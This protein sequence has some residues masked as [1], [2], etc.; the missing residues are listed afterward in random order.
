MSKRHKRDAAFQ[1]KVDEVVA[2]DVKAYEDYLVYAQT[3][4]PAKPYSEDESC[5]TFCHNTDGPHGN[6]VMGEGVMS[7]VIRFCKTHEG[8]IP[9]HP[10]D[11]TSIIRGAMFVNARNNPNTTLTVGKAEFD[12]AFMGGQ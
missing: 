9:L 4:S 10:F 11:C 1:R 2:R 5:C 3:T 7:M 12:R 6:V 8:A